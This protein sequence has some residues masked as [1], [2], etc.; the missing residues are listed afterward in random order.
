MAAEATS[1]QGL[2]IS[3]SA[4]AVDWG[5]AVLLRGGD[6]ACEGLRPPSSQAGGGIGADRGSRASSGIS[7]IRGGGWGNED[8]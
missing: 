3:G 7:G 6:G 8:S 4:I 5:S 2:R 1:R